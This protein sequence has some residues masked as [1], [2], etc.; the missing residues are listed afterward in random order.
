[1]IG[2]RIANGSKVS[3]FGANHVI[4]KTNNKINIRDAS[5]NMIG[6]RL[7]NESD[8]ATYFGINHGAY[9]IDEINKEIQKH[10]RNLTHKEADDYH[11]DN[12]GGQFEER[13]DDHLFSLHPN[14]N[15][16]KCELKSVYEVDFTHS[17]S[18]ASLLG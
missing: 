1:M 10:I 15:T 13:N 9:E 8:I 4:S 2:L 5:N 11:E 7:P 12:E 16:L 18:L 17:T 14:S 6:L 3:Y